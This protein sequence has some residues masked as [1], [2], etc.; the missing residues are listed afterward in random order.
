[1]R[2]LMPDNKAVAIIEFDSAA[3]SKNAFKK[4]HDYTVQG[5]PLYLEWAPE[6]VFPETGGLLGK[7]SEGPQDEEEGNKLKKL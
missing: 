3:H 5:T 2:F 6:G 1:M 4:L 7:R